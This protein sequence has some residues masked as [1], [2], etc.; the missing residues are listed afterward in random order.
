MKVSISKVILTW[1][2]LL[3]IILGLTACSSKTVEWNGEM[4]SYRLIMAYDETNLYEIT[5][6]VDYIF[7]GTV[8]SVIN[9]VVD[10]NSS[11]KYAAYSSYKITVGE[12][13][14][15]ELKNEVECYRHGGYLKDGT[16]LYPVSDN[17]ENTRDIPQEG[18]QYIFMA[19]GQ[20]DGSLIL[21]E[22]F[23]DIEYIG[24]EM[25][26]DY[27]DYINNEIPDNRTRF[28]SKY[29]ANYDQQK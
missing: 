11:A 26:K 24:E 13:L 10:Y 21:E 18:K 19:F 20:P 6:T 16:L 8:D 2:L 4:E 22:F 14:K 17:A 27:M 3:P 12:N 23:G 1:S 29:D 15:G 5:G 25:K 28:V 9:N 7:I